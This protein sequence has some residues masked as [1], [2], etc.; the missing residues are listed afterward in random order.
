MLIVPSVLRSAL[1]GWN[2][3]AVQLSVLMTLLD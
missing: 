1:R 2:L 3:E